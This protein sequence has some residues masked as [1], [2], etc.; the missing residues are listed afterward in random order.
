VIFTDLIPWVFLTIFDH[1]LWVTFSSHHAWPPSQ[2]QDIPNTIPGSTN[3]CRC[4][5]NPPKTLAFS[6]YKE[7]LRD[8]FHASDMLVGLPEGTQIAPKQLFY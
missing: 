6:N 4:L 3:T 8:S 1:H 7:N 2:I 5:E